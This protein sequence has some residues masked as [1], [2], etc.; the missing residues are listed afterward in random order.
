MVALLGDP[1][2]TR[3]S[4][5]GLPY[6]PFD[7]GSGMAVR[8][9]SRR[10]CV[11]LGLIGDDWTPPEKT[12]HDSLNQTLGAEIKF[13]SW[14]DSGLQFLRDSFGD[15]ITETQDRRTGAV[16]VQWRASL[17]RD[18]FRTS[19]GEQGSLL[20]LGKA[21]P[22]LVSKT[23]PGLRH[24]IQ[25]KGLGITKELITHIKNDDHWQTDPRAT[26]VP[27]QES[28][29]DLLPLI[30]RDPDA[31]EGGGKKNTLLIRLDALDGGEIHLVASLL[32][33]GVIATSF[34]KQK[35]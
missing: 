3:I 19:H 30:W 26:N 22:A 21:I 11:R 1:V 5:F 32:G 20:K 8:P 7:Y 2:W 14:Q 16:T 34:Y 12:P 24:I 23:P 33:D 27:L 13:D 10:E 25:G 31:V 4:R 6:P 35:K 9:V 28:D 18:A 29:L 15:Q 17:V